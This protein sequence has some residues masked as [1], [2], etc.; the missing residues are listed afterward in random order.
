M[1]EV[2]WLTFPKPNPKALIRLFCFPYETG[3]ASIFR[4]WP[5][6]FSAHVEICAIQLPGR[7]SRISE[8]P[9]TRMQSLIEALSVAL[10]STLSKPFAFFGHGMGAL[11]G[12]ELAHHLGERGGP[13]P[14]RLFVS[15]Q[16][17]PQ[18]TRSSSPVYNLP[19]AE[20]IE[21]LRKLQDIPEEVLDHPELME[22]MLPLLR[23]DLELSET[24]TYTPRRLLDI[25]VSAFGGLQDNEI[26]REEL[27]G[28]REQTTASCTVTM[29]PGDHFFIHSSR[30]LLL[31]GIEQVLHQT[32]TSS[33]E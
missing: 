20:F 30:K 6:S 15:G 10:S 33:G 19:D 4:G 11:I 23:A 24:Y 9:F 29:F 12:F 21:A 32:I 7:E 22:L 1:K 14:K 13:I 26:P 27:E 17:A 16:R 8:A 28:W 2:R 25:P 3:G 31:S 18:V 5:D